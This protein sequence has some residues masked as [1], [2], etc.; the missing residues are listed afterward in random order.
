MRSSLRLTLLLFTLL[1]VGAC[2]SSDEPTATES[3]SAAPTASAAA[4]GNL[5]PGCEPI[6]IRTPSGARIVLDG[7]WIE[8][9]TPVQPMTWWIRTQG[10]CVWGAGQV[11]DVPPDRTISAV[12]DLV[13]SLAGHIGSDLVITGEILWLGPMPIAAP[14]IPSRYA[15]LRMLIDV[16]DTGRILLREDR[17]PGVSG[18]RCPAPGGYCP[19][20]LVLQ[21][22]G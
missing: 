7:A 18:P 4:A 9:D 8:V 19:A 2:T 15:P 5:P 13:Q 17:E 6:D 21:P 12:P 11:D 10:D 14:S 3:P 20:P 16:D 1:A 22:A